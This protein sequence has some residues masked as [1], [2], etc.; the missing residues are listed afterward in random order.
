MSNKFLF[1]LYNAVFS[2]GPVQA[3]S[4]DRIINP[5]ISYLFHTM[6]ETSIPI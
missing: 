3:L 6:Q 4:A 2:A 5:L 1:K